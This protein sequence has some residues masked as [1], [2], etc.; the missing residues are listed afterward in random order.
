MDEANPTCNDELMELADRL[1]REYT[2]L[3]AGSYCDACRDPRAAPG[4]GGAR[5]SISSQLSRL[6]PGGAWRR[7]GPYL[8][9]RD[10][11][12]LSGTRSTSGGKFFVHEELDRLPVAAWGVRWLETGDPWRHALQGSPF[13]HGA[14]LEPRETEVSSHGAWVPRTTGGRRGRDSMSTFS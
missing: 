13:R 10:R 2:G 4:S 3:P 7:R 5:A 9:P 8:F 6:L 11:P 14:V 12:P 1:I